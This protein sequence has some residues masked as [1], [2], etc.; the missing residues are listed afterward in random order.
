MDRDM[1]VSAQLIQHLRQRR[2]C[3]F[4]KEYRLRPSIPEGLFQLFGSHDQLVIFQIRRCAV[5]RDFTIFSL[6]HTGTYYTHF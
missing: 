2:V 1:T 6:I 5:L 4:R 3:V